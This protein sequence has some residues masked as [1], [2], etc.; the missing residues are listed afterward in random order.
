MQ[1]DQRDRSTG[2][3]ERNI[4]VAPEH[5]PHFSAHHKRPIHMELVIP[6]KILKIRNVKETRSFASRL[7]TLAPSI[8]R[9]I[10]VVSLD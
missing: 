10:I 1:T 2:F 7:C 6:L 3:S 8:V 5:L 9:Q 4:R